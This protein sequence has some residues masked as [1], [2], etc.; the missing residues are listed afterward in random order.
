MKR[1]FRVF[2][3]GATLC[4]VASGRVYAAESAA[5][6]SSGASSTHHFNLRTNP[7][8]LTRPNRGWFEAYL[9][10]PIARSLT[11]GPYYSGGHRTQMNPDVWPI[12]LGEGDSYSAVYSSRGVNLRWYPGEAALS[13]SAVLD[14]AFGYVKGSMGAGADHWFD[15]DVPEQFARLSA[16]ATTLGFGG[17]MFLGPFNAEILLRYRYVFASGTQQVGN[18]TVNYSK[19]SK[20]DVELQTSIG[21]AF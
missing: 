18:M 14:A 10:I 5:S 17:Q 3:L 2:A 19:A 16:P 20:W 1:G 4:G 13:S 11:I 12:S 15:A 7:I 9:D 6:P 21:W 8:A